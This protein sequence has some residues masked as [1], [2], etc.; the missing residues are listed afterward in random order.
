MSVMAKLDSRDIKSVDVLKAPISTSIYGKSAE[1]GAVIITSKRASKP[2]VT[3][4]NRN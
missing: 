4:N 3:L 2:T 1:N